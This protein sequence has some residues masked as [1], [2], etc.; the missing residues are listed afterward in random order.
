M[1]KG[2]ALGSDSAGRSLRDR[3][4]IYQLCLVTGGCCP[5]P[6]PELPGDCCSSPHFRYKDKGDDALIR[7]RILRRHIVGGLK[8]LLL[9]YIRSVDK[10]KPAAC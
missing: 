4:A 7:W 5:P 8:E 6:P 3:S 2:V 1:F 10:E 9:I